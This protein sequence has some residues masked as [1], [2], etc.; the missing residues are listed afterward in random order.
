MF[1]VILLIYLKME[2]LIFKVLLW[3]RIKDIYVYYIV[4]YCIHKQ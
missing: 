2:K 3:N 1:S 4:L